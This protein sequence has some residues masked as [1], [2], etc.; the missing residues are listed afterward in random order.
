MF[1]PALVSVFFQDLDLQILSFGVV[2]IFL[3]TDAVIVAAMLALQELRRCRS[4][5]SAVRSLSSR[6]R[7]ALGTTNSESSQNIALNPKPYIR[8]PKP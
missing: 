1:T 4:T 6:W 3:F 8:D 5:C 7:T 2:L